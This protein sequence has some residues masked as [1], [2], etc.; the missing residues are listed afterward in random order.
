[1]SVTLSAAV[2]AAALA[3]P[4]PAEEPIK[5]P[6]GPPP[7]QII[8]S[9]TSEG[10]FEITTTALVPTIETRERVVTIGGRAVKEMY[11]VTTLKTVQVTRRIKG[12]GVKVYTVAGKEVDAKDVP[13]KLKKP[14]IVLFAVD[15]NKVDPFYLKIVKAD[16]LVIVQPQAVPTPVPDARARSPCTEADSEG[17]RQ[18]TGL[19]SPR[20]GG[21]P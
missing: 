18:A 3:A 7:Q 13:E 9:M 2:L 6:Q 4:A 11:T 8:A 14:T 12:E 16:T 5:P 20:P 1:M 19:P 10:L 21:T 17:L 15:G